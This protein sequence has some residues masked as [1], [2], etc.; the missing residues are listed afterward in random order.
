MPQAFISKIGGESRP[1]HKRS[2]GSKPQTR[3]SEEL[4]TGAIEVSFGTTEVSSPSLARSVS[5]GLSVAD[6]REVSQRADRPSLA[7]L[8]CVGKGP[9][10]QISTDMLKR[11]RGCAEEDASL[12]CESHSVCGERHESTTWKDYEEAA[13]R[14]EEAG[15]V[16]QSEGGVKSGAS[17]QMADEVVEGDK[18]RSVRSSDACCKRRQGSFNSVRQE[19][20]GVGAGLDLYGNQGSFR[21][22]LSD[23]QK[24]ILGSG[25]LFHASEASGRDG[26]RILSERDEVS[27]DLFGKKAMLGWG[28]ERQQKMRSK[29]DHA[30]A[31]L[32]CCNAKAP[33][34]RGDCFQNG[35]AK[36]FCDTVTTV[37]DL[38]DEEEVC[39]EQPIKKAPKTGAG[40]NEKKQTLLAAFFALPDKKA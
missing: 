8:R 11:A 37:I 16:G 23:G 28:K 14:C 3:A 7:V 15:W 5:C 24:G 21:S 18:T 35:D 1:K 13:I 40:L 30:T 6:S 39:S 25:G 4:D 34:R 38:R 33:S 10:D 2:G 36:K 29:R 20:A 19:G 9:G 31:D 27:V 17:I 22:K 12:L 26:V 32:S